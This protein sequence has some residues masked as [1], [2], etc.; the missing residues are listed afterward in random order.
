MKWRPPYWIRHFEFLKS[1]FK[2][3]INNPETLRIQ[4][5]RGIDEFSDVTTAISDPPFWILKIKFQIRNQRS[6]KPLRAK[7]QKN[8]WNFRFHLGHI[9][10]AILDLKNIISDSQSGTSKTLEYRLRSKTVETI[11]S[12]LKGFNKIY[13]KLEVS[14]TYF[15]NIKN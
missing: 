7:Y 8:Q 11:N 10:S 2:L 4:Y 5:F 13:P 15:C 6:Q 9:G 14:R 3:I 1:N 12:W